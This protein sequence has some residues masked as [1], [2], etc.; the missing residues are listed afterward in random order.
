MA[1][2]N[3]KKHILIAPNAFK[4]SLDAPQAAQAIADGFAQSRLHCTTTCFPIGD[5]GDGTCALI[6]T[7]LDGRFIPFTVHDPLHRLITAGFSLIH[8]GRTAVIEM[9]DASGIRLVQ[10]QELNPMRGSSY[11]TGELIRYALDQKVDHIIIGMG[12]SATVDGGCGLLQALGIR[13]LD[14]SGKELAGYP[15]ALKALHDIDLSGLDRRLKTCRITILC[16]VENTLLGTTG[17]ASVF[18]PQKGASPTEVRILDRF[19]SKL[20]TLAFEKTGRSMAEATHG[21]TAGGAAAGLFAFTHAKLVKGIDFFLDITG[22]DSVLETADW[23]VTGEGSLDSQTLEGKGPM[24]V[25]QRAKNHNIPVIGLAGKVPASPNQQ[26]LNAFNILL[27]IGNEPGSLE[28]AFASTR[29]NLQRTAHAIG[30]LI[31]SSSWHA[32]AK[33]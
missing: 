30:N 5:G 27:P 2:N 8:S 21:G 1:K 18:G 10:S 14:A 12:G 9:A 6:H 11:G 32:S 16:D 7:A 22:F 31:A 13:F 25:A 29:V 26:L 20:N 3:T 19:L 23:L 4:H 28:Q 24:G 33:Q 17:A 15:D